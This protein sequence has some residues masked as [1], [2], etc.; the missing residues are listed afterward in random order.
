MNNKTTIIYVHPYDG[1]YNHAVLE[2]VV[3][4]MKQQKINYNV[5]DIYKDGFNPVYSSE[6]LFFSRRVKH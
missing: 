6:E 5:I 3:S 4:N 2:T 1:S